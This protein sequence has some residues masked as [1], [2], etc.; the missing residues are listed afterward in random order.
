MACLDRVDLK[1]GGQDGVVRHQVARLALVC[2]HA[3]IL[4]RLRH[5]REDVEVGENADERSVARSVASCIIE[6]RLRN[7][8]RAEHAL[9]KGDVR[10]LMLPD[11]VE[12]IGLV[13]RNEPAGVQAGNVKL[14]FEVFERQCQVERIGDLLRNALRESR[15]GHSGERE[16]SRQHHRPHCELRTAL[17]QSSAARDGARE[18]FVDRIENRQVFHGC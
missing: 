11:L 16:R 6:L 10:H 14:G 2:A 1:R 17:G 13:G 12:H 9:Q 3:G 7:R 8:G 5:G 18:I 15:S 4:K